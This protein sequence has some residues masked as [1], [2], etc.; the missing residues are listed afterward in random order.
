MKS[1]YLVMAVAIVG[2]AGCA[3]NRAPEVAGKI[4]DG[5]KQAGLNDVTVS[6][7]RDKAVVTLGG[8]VKQDADRARAEQIARPIAAG[9]VIAD[10]IAVLPAGNESAARSVDSDLDRGIQANLDAALIQANIKGVDHSTKNGVV[11]LTGNLETP[12]L[13]AD[14]EHVATTVPNVQQVVNEINV[15]NQRATTSQADRSR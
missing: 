1:M 5:L 4:R 7:N 13:R 9:Q 12:Q 2:L 10:E 11:T 15:K 8:N 14:A 3:S 6:Q